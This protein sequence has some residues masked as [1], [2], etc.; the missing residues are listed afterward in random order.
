MHN[1]APPPIPGDQATHT[2]PAPDASRRDARL[3]PD[4]AKVDRRGRPSADDPLR[5][6]VPS[7]SFRVTAVGPG[8]ASS[9]PPRRRSARPRRA[10]TSRAAVALRA[11]SPHGGVAKP[12][13]RRAFTCRCSRRSPAA[14]SL[15]L[16]TTRSTRSSS[17]T[18]RGECGFPGVARRARQSSERARRAPAWAS[19][20]RAASLGAGATPAIR[21]VKMR[22]WRPCSMASKAEARTQ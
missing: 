9:P 1:R 16:M 13:P 11:I 20:A 19:S 21:S 4:T 15:A 5:V 12:G 22:T 18:P 10:P 6:W 17:V 2:E 7:A 8:G 3:S 14:L